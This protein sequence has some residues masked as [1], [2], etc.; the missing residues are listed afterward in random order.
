MISVVYSTKEKMPEFGELIKKTCGVRDVEVIEY[1]NP[2]KY[3]LSEI[4]NKGFKRIK[5]RYC[6]ILP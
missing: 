5:K 4:Y 1:V 2:G 6:C 3:S